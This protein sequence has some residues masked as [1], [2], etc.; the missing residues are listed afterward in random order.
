MKRADKV[1]VVDDDLMSLKTVRRVLEKA[2]IEGEYFRAGQEALAGDGRARMPPPDPGT[3]RR[4]VPGCEGR[5]PYRQR[6]RGDGDPL[7]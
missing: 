5:L 1:V 7:P 4:F 3:G 2:G 6:G